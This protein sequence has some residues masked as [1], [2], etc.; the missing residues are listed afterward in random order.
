LVGYDYGGPYLGFVNGDDPIMVLRGE[1]RPVGDRTSD[2]IDAAYARV[3]KLKVSE[4]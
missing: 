2:A 1:T 3:K 4:S